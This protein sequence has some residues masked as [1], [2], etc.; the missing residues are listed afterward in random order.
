MTIKDFTEWYYPSV[1]EKE[2]FALKKFVEEFVNI[3]DYYTILNILSRAG[4]KSIYDLY[5]ADEK[6]IRKVRNVGPK[7]MELIMKM[8]SAI[9]Q[10]LTKG[11]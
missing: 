6:Q 8:K 10:N 4:I 11:E 9:D 5:N 7:R 3:K 1:R 2:I